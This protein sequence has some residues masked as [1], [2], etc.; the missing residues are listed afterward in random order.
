M[1][2][3]PTGGSMKKNRRIR[4]SKDLIGSG[5][6]MSAAAP[7]CGGDRVTGSATLILRPMQKKDG[8]LT[9]L[10]VIKKSLPGTITRKNLR[11]SAAA[12]MGCLNYQMDSICRPWI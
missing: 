10:C 1:K 3:I 8:R 4:R 11:A 2:A 5:V 9:G 6:I 12:G 7:Y